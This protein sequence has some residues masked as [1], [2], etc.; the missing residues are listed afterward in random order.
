MTAPRKD[1]LHESNLAHRKDELHESHLL[2][3]G[4]VELVLPM[5]RTSLKSDS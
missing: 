1:E 5:G 4:L 2:N 3:Q